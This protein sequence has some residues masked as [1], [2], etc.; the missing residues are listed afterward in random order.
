MNKDLNM[1]VNVLPVLT[2]GFLRVNDSTVS[3]SD[4]K[5]DSELDNLDGLNYLAKKTVNYVNRKAMEGTI[6][7]HVDG[8]VP[9]III[10][11]K[12][13]YFFIIDHLLIL[14]L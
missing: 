9:N 6:Q 3:E 8:G 2:Y 1:K 7:A 12:N 10:K 11:A 5:I 14:S 13:T 4:I